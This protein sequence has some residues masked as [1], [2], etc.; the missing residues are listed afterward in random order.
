[1]PL[2]DLSQGWETLNMFYPKCPIPE[3][4]HILMSF[5]K[6]PSSYGGA[7]FLSLSGFFK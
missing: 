6:L 1:M 4:A 7:D 5:L 3:L 2:D